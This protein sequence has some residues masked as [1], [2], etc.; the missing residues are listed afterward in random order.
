[1][2][3]SDDSTIAAN[4][5]TAASDSSLMLSMRWR[6]EMSREIFEIPDDAAVAAAQR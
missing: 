6:S 1:M 4:W 5:R 3:S 2:P